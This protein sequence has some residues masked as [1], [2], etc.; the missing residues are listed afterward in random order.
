MKKWMIVLY[1]IIS[2]LLIYLVMFNSTN[3]V[4]H[5]AKNVM[6]G[7]VDISVTKG[8]PLDR[9]N[10]SNI[11]VNAKVKASI[12]RLFVWHDFFDGY[13]W[14]IYSYETVKNGKDIKPGM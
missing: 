4:V 12:I 6:L 2:I 9:Y 13:M 8:T 7:N 1:I 11:L 3:S 14:V 10:F 5:D